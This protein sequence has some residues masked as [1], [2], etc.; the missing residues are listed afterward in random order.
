MLNNQLSTVGSEL[1]TLAAINVTPGRVLNDAPLPSAPSS[2]SRPIDLG[3]GLLAGLLLG[4][5]VAFVLERADRKVR[6]ADAAS[7]R[8]AIPLLTT[9]RPSR[10]AARLVDPDDSGAMQYDRLRNALAGMLADRELTVDD[11]AETVVVCGATAGPT[12]GV[13]VA[14]L[15]VT[16]ARSGYPVTLICAD[17]SSSSLQ[18]L[19]VSAETPGLAQVLGDGVL[20]RDVGQKVDQPGLTVIGPGKGTVAMLDRAWERLHTPGAETDAITLIEVPFGQAELLSRRADVTLAVAVLGKTTQTMLSDVGASLDRRTTRLVA[21]PSASGRIQARPPVASTPAPSAGQTS[22][23][24]AA[25]SVSG[26][27]SSSSVK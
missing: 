27:G 20:L 9:T 25:K 23:G 4:L 8:A 24:T 17:R 10:P 14:N 13:V 1:S 16:L 22:T 18:L 6:T 21:V 7:R 12:T 5:I 15:A 19:G 11:A 26:T 3:G 2:P